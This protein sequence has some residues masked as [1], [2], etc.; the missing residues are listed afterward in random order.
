MK[1]RRRSAAF[2]AWSVA[3]WSVFERRSR[4]AGDA[5]PV[6]QA[7]ARAAILADPPSPADRL[8]CT[9]AGSLLE[10]ALQLEALRDGS[11]RLDLQSISLARLMDEVALE[12]GPL[13]RS[14]GLR[15][16]QAPVPATAAEW[17]T[18]ASLLRLVV[19]HLSLRAL[20][21][22]VA[23]GPVRLDVAVTVQEARLRVLSRGTPPASRQRALDGVSELSAIQRLLA[24]LGGALVIEPR[25][26]G[27]TPLNV[28]LRAAAPDACASALS[29]EAA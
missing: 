20:V 19:R 5:R 23:P 29:R 27:Y 11:A 8:A 17:R 2:G 4:P 25:R 12:L 24:A 9:Y 6:V 28:I 21:G 22:E 7:P 16:Q 26:S 1:A 13:A 14:A 10:V 15:L 3:P 18:D